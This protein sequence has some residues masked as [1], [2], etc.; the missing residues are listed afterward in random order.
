MRRS[1]IF[2]SGVLSFPFYLISYILRK[3]FHTVIRT[4]LKNLFFYDPNSSNYEFYEILKLPTLK[5]RLSFYICKISQR[6]FFLVFLDE[7]FIYNLAIAK[8]VKKKN[9]QIVSVVFEKKM[10]SSQ[11]FHIWFSN[12]CCSLPRQSNWVLFKNLDSQLICLE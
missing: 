11:P 4:T 5:N 2:I 10:H 9:I 6:F 8:S 3:I 7:R 1:F 12:C